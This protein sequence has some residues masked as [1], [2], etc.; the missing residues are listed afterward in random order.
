MC[1]LDTM[2]SRT[3]PCALRYTIHGPIIDDL[4]PNSCYSGPKGTVF[5]GLAL[6][7]A[8][9]SSAQHAPRIARSEGVKTEIEGPIIDVS[10]N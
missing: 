7:T 6:Y 10:E 9:H 1:V 3:D 8:L 5:T 2:T 4:R